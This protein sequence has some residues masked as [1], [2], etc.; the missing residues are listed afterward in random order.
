MTEEL[1]RAEAAL[2]ERVRRYGLVNDRISTIRVTEA[3][4]NGVSATVDAAGSLVQ[5]VFDDRVRRLN[6][7]QLA[8]EALAC[9]RRAQGG[10]A[11]RV[12]EAVT[13]IVGDDEPG[14][15][16]VAGLRGQFPAPALEAML[17]SPRAPSAGRH[18]LPDDD[19]FDAGIMQRVDRRS[20]NG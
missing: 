5:L 8:A 11:D 3:S 6:P 20:S 17:A 2:S 12:G 18:A 10:I 14:R 1:A 13:E 9:V 19:G 7:T 15:R 4:N 16:I